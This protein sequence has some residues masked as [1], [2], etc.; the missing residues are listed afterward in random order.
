MS[1]GLLCRV[2]CAVPSLFLLLQIASA[3]I[4]TQGALA[5]EGE[6]VN[7]HRLSPLAVIH[8][9]LPSGFTSLNVYLHVIVGPT[10]RVES[11]R[12]E[13]LDQPS[14]KWAIDQA[15]AAEKQ[16][17]FRPFKKN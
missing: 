10:G 17:R 2:T 1:G 11:V 7:K 9:K 13:N 3:Q 8:E 16:Q 14:D 12:A 4:Q 15:V 6:Q 5:V